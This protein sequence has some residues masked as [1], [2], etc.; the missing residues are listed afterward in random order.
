MKAIILDISPI[1]PNQIHLER[2]NY[3]VS[4]SGQYLKIK[5]PE[6]LKQRRI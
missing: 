4:S 5:A 6:I 1:V 2:Q 3:M